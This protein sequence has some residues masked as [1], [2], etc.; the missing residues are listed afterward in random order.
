M[1]A[2]KGIAILSVIA[3]HAAQRAG[4]LPSLLASAL[5]AGRYGVQMFFLVSGLTVFASMRRRKNEGELRRW[6]HF[7]LRRLLRLAPLA[8]I[9][10]AA[11]V[12]VNHATVSAPSVF[13][14]LTFTSGWI[15]GVDGLLLG[16]WVLSAEVAFYLLTPAFLRIAHSL[17]SAATLAVILSLGA[18]G[19]DVVVGSIWPALR[20]SASLYF[21]PPTQLPFMAIGV[22][23]YHVSEANDRAATA[24]RPP[25]R[26]WPWV[27]AAALLVASVLT[28]GLHWLYLYP[29]TFAVGVLFSSGSLKALVN[30]VTVW[31][32]KISFSVFVWHFFVLDLVKSMLGRA[33]QGVAGVTLLLAIGVAGSAA[34][35]W[36]SNRLIEQPA[37][38]LARRLTRDPEPLRSE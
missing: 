13:T 11:N 10:A 2:A 17:R 6:S 27:I 37:I 14:T 32:G 31:L 21:W 18:Y 7:C 25:A 5:G 23:L 24:S 3:V 30:P 1:D 35:G 29:A 26:Q 38:R 16:G 8:Y 20:G 22:L 36:I 33:A 12:I 9:G 34:M 15:P 4:T 28:H 19:L